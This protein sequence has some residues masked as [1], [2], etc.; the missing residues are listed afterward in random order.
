MLAFIIIFNFLQLELFVNCYHIQLPAESI[1]E[2]AADDIIHRL[3]TAGYQ[4]F[5]VGGAVRDRLL[6]RSPEEVDVATDAV[7]T[8]V[9]E[10]FPRSY[11]VGESFGVIVVHTQEGVD[12]EVATFREENEYADG[13]HP[14]EVHFSTPEK[15]AAR[16]DFTVNALYY[17]PSNSQLLDFVNGR[18]DLQNRIIRAIGNPCTRFAED[19]LRILRA[20]RFAAGLKFRLDPSTA[21]ACKEYAEQ[22]SAISAERVYGEL[23]RMLNSHTAAVAFCMLHRLNMLDQW[24]PEVERMK[25]VPQPPQFHPEGDVWQH[26]LLMLGKMREPSEELGWAVLLHD[27]GKPPT[28][29]YAPDRIR[30]PKHAERSAEIAGT[31]LRRLRAS[32]KL[33]TTVQEC[34]KNHMTFSDVQNM[35]KSTLRRL[36][37]RPT[38]PIELE[39][40]RLDCEASHRKLDNYH[41]LRDKETEFANEPVLPEPILRGHDILALGI[42][43]GPLVGELL[44][45]AWQW[46]LEGEIQDKEEALQKVQKYLEAKHGGKIST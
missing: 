46:Q 29:E 32:K 37:G 18:N 12:V 27:V 34:V 20:V 40:H 31:V 8:K 23:T 45:H 30:F 43:P 13:R 15:D 5:R 2:K 42:E 24:L 1:H 38:F 41:Y 35:K 36:M 25:G 11:A 22:L 28:I 21:D 14:G 9:K 19:H 4:A 16:R 3:H 6:G 33:I 10:L 7:P 39:L 44:E 17:D 26:T